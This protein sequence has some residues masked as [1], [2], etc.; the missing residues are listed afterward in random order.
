MPATL[1]ASGL[2]LSPRRIEDLCA[3]HPFEPNLGCAPEAVR[4]EGRLHANVRYLEEERSRSAAAM[5]GLMREL[6][7]DRPAAARARVARPRVSSR[8]QA[9]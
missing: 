1:T 3:R 5:R 2:T 6:D 7:I 9:P 4:T 8:P